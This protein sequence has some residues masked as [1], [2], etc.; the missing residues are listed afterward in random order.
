MIT[1]HVVTRHHVTTVSNNV[2]V[3]VALLLLLQHGWC[4]D[5]NLTQLEDYFTNIIDEQLGARRVQV[6]ATALPR[7]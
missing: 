1:N 4:D 6:S 7:L 5:F 2:S 3:L